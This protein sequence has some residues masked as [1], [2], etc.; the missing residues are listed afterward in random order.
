MSSSTPVLNLVLYSDASYLPHLCAC[1]RSVLRHLRRNAKIR[2]FVLHGD[3]EAM[4]QESLEAIVRADSGVSVDWIPIQSDNYEGSFTPYG[5]YVS[6]ASYY[7]LLVA[8]L[9]PQDIERAVLLDCDTIV[10][11]DLVELTE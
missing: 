6:Q 7:R 5:G 9:L 11:G 10:L 4:E 3:K 8:S 1:V 2:L